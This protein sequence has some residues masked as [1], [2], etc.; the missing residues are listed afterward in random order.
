MTTV[1]QAIDWA[2]SFCQTG[3]LKDLW[4]YS[5]FLPE[6]SFSKGRFF[7]RIGDSYLNC[8]VTRQVL[9]FDS[10]IGVSECS[11]N[12]PFNHMFFRTYQKFLILF[13]Y[14]LEIS[15]FFRTYQK[16]L[17]LFL[18]P[19]EINEYFTT[20]VMKSRLKP[21]SSLTNTISSCGFVI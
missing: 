21:F 7:P 12:N 14:P 19:L 8:I 2:Y 3:D 5:S 16:F 15:E 17:I 11:Y 4:N 1:P 18:Y 10:R 20:E 6:Q 9:P 13:L